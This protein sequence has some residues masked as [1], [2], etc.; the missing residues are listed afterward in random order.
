MIRKQYDNVKLHVTVINSIFR[1]NLNLE[2][3]FD[4]KVRESFDASYILEKYKKFYFGEADFESIQLS[5]RFSTG[6]NKYYESLFNI[7]F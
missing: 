2:T 1:K 5:V 6:A 3:P 4:N 7:S